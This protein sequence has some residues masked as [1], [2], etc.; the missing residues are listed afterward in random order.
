MPQ[1]GSVHSKEEIFVSGGPTGNDAGALEG[2]LRWGR[3]RC[4][5]KRLNGRGRRSSNNCCFVA[6]RRCREIASRSIHGRQGRRE[7]NNL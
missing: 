4:G 6:T 1:Q 3:R 5:P 7:L 2:R